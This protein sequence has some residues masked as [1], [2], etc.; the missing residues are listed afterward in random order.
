MWRVF[1]LLKQENACATQRAVVLRIL[2]LCYLAAF[3]S[4][5]VQIAGLWGSDG[6]LPVNVRR[7][8]GFPE[9]TRREDADTASLQQGNMRVSESCPA[10]V[11]QRCD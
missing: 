2:A 11:L 3:S 4:H 7:Q 1:A 9:K 6:I 10:D 8:A 5:Y